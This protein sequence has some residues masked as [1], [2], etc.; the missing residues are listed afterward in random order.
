MARKISGTS[1]S[2]A[3]PSTQQHDAHFGKDFEVMNV[4]DVR[5]GSQRADGD[6]AQNKSE[7]QWEPQPPR[8]QAT[9]HG[10]HENIG[11]IAEENRVGFHA[12]SPGVA[13]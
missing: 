11:E 4:R 9:Q 1:S 5:P 8:H 13:V 6:A 3:L 12:S 10:G 7:D 2:S